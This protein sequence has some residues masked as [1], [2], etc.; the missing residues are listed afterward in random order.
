MVRLEVKMFKAVL[1]ELLV[2][3][4]HTIVKQNESYRTALRSQDLPC[5]YSAHRELESVK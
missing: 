5:T 4:H 1:R 2:V 3:L